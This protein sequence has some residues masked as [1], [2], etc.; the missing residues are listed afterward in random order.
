MKY[1][2]HRR[3]KGR[4]L[5][6]EVNI[7]AC[8]ELSTFKDALI[9]NEKPI[10]FIESEN[11]HQYF[12]RNDDGQGLLRGKLTQAIQKTLQNQDEHYQ[13]R[14]NKIW[15]DERCSKFKRIEHKDFWLWNNE[16][17]RAQIDELK[18]IADL[19]GAKVGE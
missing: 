5:C 8:S 12:A 10:C 11:G 9:W 14:W 4:A 17:Y 15:A 6:G 7:P 16:F 3:F 1:I 2:C 13:D 19:I 18:Y